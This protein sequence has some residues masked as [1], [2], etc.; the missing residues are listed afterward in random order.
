MGLVRRG[1]LGRGRQLT[2]ESGKWGGQ[3][4]RGDGS[5]LV[6]EAQGSS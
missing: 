4:G 6:A 5:G 3:S 1:G 2:R